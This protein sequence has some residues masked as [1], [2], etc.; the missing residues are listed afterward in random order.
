VPEDLSWDTRSV[1]K[2]LSQVNTVI[3]GPRARGT[4]KVAGLLFSSLSS[5][6]LETTLPPPLRQRFVAARESLGK[7]AGHY[8]NW[9]PAAA[10]KALLDD[11][12]SANGLRQG[13]IEA[14]VVKLA[15]GHGVRDVPAGEFDPEALI[16]QAKALSFNT[17]LTCLDA[18][19]H[20]VERGAGVIRAVATSWAKGEVNDAPIDRVDRACVLTLPAIDAQAELTLTQETTAVA[21]ALMA[22]GHA[23]A[24]FEL[25]NLTQPGGVIDRLRARGYQVSGPIS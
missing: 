10:S 23:M 4:L 14:S 18:A 13:G 19:V 3:V 6:P 16:D 9:K 12:F 25:H 15:H 7:P 20:D 2:R 11:F 5:Q 24:V 8:A 21:Q 22:P 1:E 17:Q